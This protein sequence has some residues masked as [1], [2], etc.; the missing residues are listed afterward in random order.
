MSGVQVNVLGL[1]MVLGL[2][3][4]A[5][6]VV[7]AIAF[8]KKRTGALA[9]GGL[10]LL[11]ILGAGLAVNFRSAR[12]AHHQVSLGEQRATALRQYAME[13]LHPTQGV[14]Q[15][16]VTMNAS[17]RSMS[18]GDASSHAETAAARSSQR[19]A[20]IAL[21]DEETLVLSGDEVLSPSATNPQFAPVIPTPAPPVVAVS[22][23]D[24]GGSCES[25][26]F[27][28][29]FSDSFGGYLFRGGAFGVLLILAYLF[30]DAGRR[31]RYTWP[32]RFGTVVLFAALCMLLLKSGRLM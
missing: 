5:G 7:L 18:D 11:V 1:G 23:V 19:Q 22:E 3:L 27:P 32:M 14:L 13:K 6:V 26:T 8:R 4:L 12:T 29:M 16:I 20:T 28:C 31:G 30:L 2:I 15:T 17:S 9:V 10:V 25:E 24:T 21:S